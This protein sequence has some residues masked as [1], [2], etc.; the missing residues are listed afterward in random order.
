MEGATPL[1]GKQE[2]RWGQFRR[3]SS[4]HWGTGLLA[5]F[6]SGTGGGWRLMHEVTA[7][8]GARGAG[9][10]AGPAPSAVSLRP[11]LLFGG[12]LVAQQRLHLLQHWRCELG[13]HLRGT[14]ASGSL[15][16]TGSLEPEG[17]QVSRPP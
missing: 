4:S 5:R 11:G 10:L 9:T 7:N 13:Q 17:T 3:A 15:G 14:Q 16:L 2:W 6:Q 12:W 1:R 8:P